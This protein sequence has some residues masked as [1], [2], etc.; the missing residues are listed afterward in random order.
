MFLFYSALLTPKKKL[1]I[2]LISM[3]TSMKT[4]S[5]WNRFN[6]DTA[7]H[8][9]LQSSPKV[10]LTRYM[11][12]GDMN[13]P[14]ESLIATA[15]RTGL[16]GRALIWRTVKNLNLKCQKKSHFSAS[17]FVIT[18]LKNKN[19]KLFEKLLG[20]TLWLVATRNQ[21]PAFSLDDTDNQTIVLSLW[22]T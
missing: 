16:G 13:L 4:T 11:L 8:D 21:H 14:F 1:N 15:T 6:S 22:R 12:A 9:L 2:S 17:V 7:C 5:T 19:K 3:N 10:P 18:Y 20:N